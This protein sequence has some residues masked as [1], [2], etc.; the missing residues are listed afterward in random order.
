MSR[1]NQHEDV[2]F[3]VKLTQTCLHETDTPDRNEVSVRLSNSMYVHLISVSHEQLLW[4]LLLVNSPPQKKQQQ[5]NSEN[6][7]DNLMII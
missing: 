1:D 3:D 6:N 5:R 4:K 2:D 7:I